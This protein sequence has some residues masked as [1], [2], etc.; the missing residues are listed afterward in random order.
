MNSFGKK[1]WALPLMI[2][3]ILITAC[4][5]GLAGCGAETYKVTFDAN[6]GYFGTTATETTFVK[7]DA[8]KD[9][10]LA[11]ILK[12]AKKSV[13]R[14]DTTTT[15]YT[16]AG[17]YTEKEG[18][19]EVTKVSDA[20]GSQKEATVY[21]HWDVA[22]K[23]STEAEFK[24]AIESKTSKIVLK[25][26]IT[27]TGSTVGYDDC[28]Y[29]TIDFDC[30]MDLGGFT[31]KGDKFFD[32]C[33]S[34]SNTAP[35]FTI[36]NG[37]I[38]SKYWVA[39]VKDHNGILTLD[40]VVATTTD[41]PLT[42]FV[43]GDVNDKEL[44]HPQVV[45]GNGTQVINKCAVVETNV[46]NAAVG[47]FD[48]AKMT[49][50]SGSKADYIGDLRNGL[51]TAVIVDHSTFNMEK[52]ASIYSNA[53]GVFA[54]KQSNVVINGKIYSYSNGVSTSPYKDEG[55]VTLAINSDADITSTA[56]VALYVANNDT[57]N[58]TGATLYG[59]TALYI[60]SGNTTINGGTFKAWWTG[61]EFK[62]YDN[63]CCSTGDVIVIEACNWLG[64]KNVPNVTVSGDVEYEKVEAESEESKVNLD[65]LYVNYNNATLGT[66]KVD[67][68]EM[69][70]NKVVTPS[71]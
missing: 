46:L 62:H 34:E 51:A 30:V 20:L 54:F 29:F 23:V 26:D 15:A 32:V 7:N 22:V 40:K 3:S 4:L 66:V 63:G 64:D 71:A 44:Y 67:G 2:C 17:W 39:W 48:G 28:P 49:M 24:T 11:D 10:K 25:N 18:G 69:E 19:K 13:N 60:K 31:L 58:I 33:A 42:V 56:T 5:F 43:A 47:L 8:T 52:G 50:A 37:A 61:S 1:L 70:P 12:D 59:A 27:L 21:A 38:E 16:F 35:K 55:G 14:A 6:G 9:S 53:Q 45:L 57:V 41:Y 36:T 65:I 68:T